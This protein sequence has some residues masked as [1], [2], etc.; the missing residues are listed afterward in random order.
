MFPILCTIV[1]HSCICF[2]ATPPPPPPPTL[3]TTSI[4]TPIKETQTNTLLCLQS[5]SVFRANEQT[6]ASD[7]GDGSYEIKYTDDNDD[8]DYSNDLNE[9]N[10]CDVMSEEKRRYSFFGIESLCV[11]L[12]LSSSAPMSHEVGTLYPVP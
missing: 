1:L 2:R 7:D 5:I 6:Y 8:E 12:V 9:E 11:M 3:S 10:Q 4:T